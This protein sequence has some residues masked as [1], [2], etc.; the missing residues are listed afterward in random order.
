VEDRVERYRQLLG[1]AEDVAGRMSPDELADGIAELE[2]AK[3]LLSI[4]LNTLT[5][6][7]PH[8]T[9]R[10]LTAKEAAERLGVSLETVYRKAKDV[11]F[12]VKIG[13]NLR[14]SSHGLEAFIRSRCGQR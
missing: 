11:P 2:R 6:S 7:R 10:L 8:E 4:R 12:R 3:A 1:E 9:D 14:F 13:G 5:A